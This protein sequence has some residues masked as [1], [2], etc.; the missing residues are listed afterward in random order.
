M[1]KGQAGTDES[2]QDPRLRC[3]WTADLE[4]FQ[5]CHGVALPAA[6]AR[7]TAVSPVGIPGGHACRTAGH[8]APM[9][10]RLPLTPCE[11]LP[12]FHPLFLVF[13]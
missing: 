3:I 11:G 7:G 13:P 1:E 6:V 12:S 4:T 9:P 10:S 8:E 2:T 5:G